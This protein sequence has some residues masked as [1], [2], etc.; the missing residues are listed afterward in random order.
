[1]PPSCVR[2]HYV[3]ERMFARELCLDRFILLRFLRSTRHPEHCGQSD[4]WCARI[5]DYRESVIALRWTSWHSLRRRRVHQV[6]SAFA[7]GLDLSFAGPP[8]VIVALNREALAAYFLVLFQPFGAKRVWKSNQ[9]LGSNICSRE[10]P[11][12]PEHIGS[13]FSKYLG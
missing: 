11:G 3:G 7:A 12:P 5:P 6:V 2:Q 8:E 4:F 1:M 10:S 13:M 9:E